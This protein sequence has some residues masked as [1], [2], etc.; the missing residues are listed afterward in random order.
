MAN[1]LPK[2]RDRMSALGKVGGTKSGESRR[3]KALTLDMYQAILFRTCSWEEFCTTTVEELVERHLFRAKRSG[4]SHD[5]DWRCPTCR[6]FNSEKRR[7]C[8]K[9]GSVVLAIG[10]VTRKAF[11]ERSAERQTSAFLGK[12]GL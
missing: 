7:A 1:Y 10:R 6:H 4:G 3:D 8:A 5:N 11:R 2:G 9:C 12:H